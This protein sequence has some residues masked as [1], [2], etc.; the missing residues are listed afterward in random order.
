MLSVPQVMIQMTTS[1][2]MQ[3]SQHLSP[4]GNGTCLTL[5]CL[6]H[7]Q[8]SWRDQQTTNE[9]SAVSSTHFLSAPLKSFLKG[10]LVLLASDASLQCDTDMLQKPVTREEEEREEQEKRR[11]EESTPLGIDLIRSQVLHRAA[12]ETCH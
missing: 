7:G 9:T 11:K 2:L 5:A 4:W 8:L 10:C 6:G 3:V 1:D 12:Q